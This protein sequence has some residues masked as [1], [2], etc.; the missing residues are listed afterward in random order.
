[1]LAFDIVFLHDEMTV[2]NGIE[3]VLAVGRKVN[4]CCEVYV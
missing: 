3:Y 2:A 1:M 4:G